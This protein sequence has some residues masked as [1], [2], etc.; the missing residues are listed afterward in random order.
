MSETLQVTGT[1][2]LIARHAA[3]A[4]WL[5]RYVERIE[6]LARIARRDQD[7]HARSTATG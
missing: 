4:L 5:A 7:V 2:R 6:N 3:S 1:M